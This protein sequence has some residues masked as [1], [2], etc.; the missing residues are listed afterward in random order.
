MSGDLL[1]MGGELAAL[2]FVVGMLDMGFN[3]C[4]NDG[5]FSANRRDPYNGISAGYVV[6][7]GDEVSQEIYYRR[8]SSL[9]HGPLQF[10]YGASV[11]A[12]GDLWG[13]AGASI[14]SDWEMGHSDA[15]LQLSLIPGVYLQN[16]GPDLGGPLSIRSGIEFG[17]EAKS[18]IRYAISLDHRS[19]GGAY[20]SNPGLETLQLRVSIPLR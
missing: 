2:F 13:G 4:P 9:A 10:T 1:E 20:Q 15:F 18:G 8:E 12:D 17:L 3:H 19:N 6:F 14:R 11:T 16:G 7:E 5:C